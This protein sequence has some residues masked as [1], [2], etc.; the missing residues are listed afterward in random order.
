MR[1]STLII[2]LLVA[3]LAY[4]AY[5]SRPTMSLQEAVY[6][7]EV[8]QVKL[9]FLWRTDVNAKFGQVGQEGTL[10]LDTLSR[11]LTGMTSLHIAAKRGEKDLAK[12]LIEH[13]A[14]VNARQEI[15]QQDETGLKLLG[16]TPLHLALEAGHKDLARLLIAKGADV[17]ADAYDDGRP[18]DIAAYDGHED[19]VELLISNGAKITRDD[20]RGS[21]LYPAVS[22][23]HRDIAVL[24]ILKGAD[25]NQKDILFGR[26]PLHLAWHTSTAEL[27][28]A[29]GADVN[30][31]D[32]SGQRPLHRMALGNRKDVAELLIARGA[33]VNAKDN[34]GK[35]PLALA[36]EKGHEEIVALLRAHGADE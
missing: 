4:C 24:L 21:V 10:S 7:G 33:E 31:K 9:H 13:G 1:T 18:I 14:D 3:I 22:G 27:L 34:E 2:L 19:M 5:W 25:V 23:G 12:L 28:I 20:G 30:A 36:K 15:E 11:E 32:K 6:Y 29:E 35:N 26:T 8:K 16:I 17:N